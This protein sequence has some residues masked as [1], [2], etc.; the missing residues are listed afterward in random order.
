MR[1]FRRVAEAAVLL[2]EQMQRG[3][4]H[5]VD[6]AGIE[7]AARAVKHF[8]FGD[9]F[10]ERVGGVVHFARGDCESFGNAEENAFEAGAAHGVFGREI[11]AAEKRLA[12][13]REERGERPAALSGNG[14]DRGLIARVDVGALV[15]IHFHGNVKLIDHRRDFGIFVALAVDHV[16]PVAPD[17][18]DIEQDRFAFGARGLRKLASPHSYQSIGWCAA[19]R[20]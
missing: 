19:E 2:V 18:A 16:A 14:A 8:R 1:K 7:L 4:D 11:G 12:V 15:A 20:R 13:G 3:F 5:R 10:F 6:D 9:G 17:G